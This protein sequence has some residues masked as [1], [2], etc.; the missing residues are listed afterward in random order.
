VNLVHS[1]VVV[2]AQQV[3]KAQVWWSRPCLSRSSSAAGS[4]S[5]SLALVDSVAEHRDCYIAQLH[6]TEKAPD[7]LK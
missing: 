1:D 7:R 6:F 3:E 5:D 4:N 2:L